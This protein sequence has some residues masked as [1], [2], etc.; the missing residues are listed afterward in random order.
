[1][2]LECEAGVGGAAWDE[3]VRS[4]SGS[5]FHSSAWSRYITRARS[6]TSAIRFRL[7]GDQGGTIGAA[8]GFRTRHRNPLVAPLTSELWFDAMPAVQPVPGAAERFVELLESHATGAGDVEIAFGSFGYRG[9]SEVLRVRQYTLAER[10][11]FELDLSPSLDELLKALEHKRRKNINK[12]KRAGVAVEDLAVEGG[13]LQLYRLH[14]ITWDRLEG[15]GITRRGGDH[16]TGAGAPERELL[17]SGVG[18]LIGARLD[19]E[20]LT[21]SLFTRFADQVYHVLSGHSPKALEVQA[22]TQL[23]WE[24]IA[25][26]RAEGARWFNFG[27]CAASARQPDAPEHGVFEYKRA[28]G[29]A[30]L[31]CASGRRVLRPRRAAL[32]RLLRA[33]TGH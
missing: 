27:G 17:E 8:L 9:G 24:S 5:V 7:V 11:E 1:V 3:T 14:E 28:F 6:N 23:L 20:W 32:A 19:G 2:Q 33:M 18:R 29:G 12:S 10:M 21:V 13:L 16:A 25:R 31:E 30:C 26:Y 15:R 4:C 22:P